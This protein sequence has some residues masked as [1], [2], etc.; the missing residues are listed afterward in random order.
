MDHMFE[1]PMILEELDVLFKDD[2][3]RRMMVYYQPEEANSE[4]EDSSTVPRTRRPHHQTEP[5]QGNFRSN[6]GMGILFHF[7]LRIL[8][9]QLM[10]LR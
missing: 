2:T 7:Q 9:F 8:F 1:N 10:D 3:A 6:S 5:T 4:E